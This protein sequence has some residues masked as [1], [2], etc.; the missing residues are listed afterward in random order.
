M[1]AATGKHALITVEARQSTKLHVPTVVLE[2]ECRAYTPYLTGQLPSRYIVEKYQDFHQKIGLS[3][4]QPYEQFLL[5]MSA[6]GP[7]WA[8]L[9]DSYVSFWRKDSVVRSKIV[10][11]LALLE[12]APPSFESLDAVPDGG[13]IGAVL[14]LAS[15]AARYGLT[16]IVASI[17]FTPVSL[18]MSGRER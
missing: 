8:R 12:C 9:V 14:R 17:L 11:T 15:G 1:I 6:R 3:A 2:R 13:W 16:L 10:L 5:A 18:W 4:V 7:E